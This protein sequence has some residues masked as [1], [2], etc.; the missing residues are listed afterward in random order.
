M[1]E[2]RRKIVGIQGILRIKNQK[3]SI[4]FEVAL[5]NIFVEFCSSVNMFFLGS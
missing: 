4:D 1:T 5:S 2:N 3:M